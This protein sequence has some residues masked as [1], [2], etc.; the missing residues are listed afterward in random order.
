MAYTVPQQ[1]QLKIID[2]KLRQESV[3]A[4]PLTYFSGVYNE[5]MKAIPDAVM[6]KV[7]S[8]NGEF[9][10]TI[11]V[12]L[13]LIGS[14]VSGRSPVAGSEEELQTRQMTLRANTYGNAVPTL[15]WGIDA[16]LNKAVDIL[17]EVQ[18]ALSQW[19]KEIAGLK[20]RQA[21]CQI[22]SSEQT[23]APANRFM[24]LNPN[25]I[26]S[27]ATGATRVTFPG[28]TV[29][30]FTTNI[31]AAASAGMGT[32]TLAASFGGLDTL[33]AI[34]EIA[35]LYIAMESF[36]DS[37]LLLTLPTPVFN[38]LYKVISTNGVVN[39]VKF[40]AKNGDPMAL[41]GFTYGKLTVMNDP[42]FPV[43]NV[44]SGTMTWYY[45]Q[46]GGAD[47]RLGSKVA[48]SNDYHVGLLSG[49]GAIFEFESSPLQFRENVED[50]QRN[51]GVGA[52]RVCGYTAG[53][54]SNDPSVFGTGLVSSNGTYASGVYN[55]ASAVVLFP[56]KT[57]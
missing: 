55:K 50:Y 10:H 6:T 27:N 39:T 12:R 9:E 21:A 24:G 2:A 13:A 8:A 44:A 43:L 32:N 57:W 20:I 3:L 29:A 42:R 38:Q 4:D 49:K 53:V 16:D 19:H 46:P 33:S 14:G 22:Y 30:A 23:K 28:T 37:S 40:D 51:V 18:P 35:D 45:K 34:Q 54:F 7:S 47:A 56:G 1:L 48:T 5:K 15:R 36:G 25:F 11:A 41:V 17:G 31:V 26:V 52:F